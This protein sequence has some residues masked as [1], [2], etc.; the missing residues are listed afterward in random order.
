MD[1]DNFITEGS[2]S[3]VFFI[4]NNVIYTPPE[5]MVLKGITR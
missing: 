4:K 3:N 2:K 5:N 1:H